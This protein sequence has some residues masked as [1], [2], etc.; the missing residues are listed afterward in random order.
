M[1]LGWEPD[2][3]AL[4][5]SGTWGLDRVELRRVMP[6]TGDSASLDPPIFFGPAEAFG[7]F[8]MTADGSVIAHLSET[9]RG[10]IWVAELGEGP[11]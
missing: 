3:E 9:R 7:Q 8:D 10:N 4:L 11:Q 1:T 6:S 2:G 5:V